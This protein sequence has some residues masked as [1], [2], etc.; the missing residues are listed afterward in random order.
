M[1][2]THEA[3]TEGWRLYRDEIFLVGILYNMH[4]TGAATNH[5]RH[6][7]LMDADGCGIHFTDPMLKVDLLKAVLEHIEADGLVG[8]DPSKPE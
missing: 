5:V 4:D 8:K 3:T 1:K 6:R 2:I 7:S